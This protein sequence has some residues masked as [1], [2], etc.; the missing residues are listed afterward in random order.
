MVKPGMVAAVAA[1]L[2]S[3]LVVEVRAQSTPAADQQSVEAAI[4]AVHVQLVEAAGKLDANAL[5]GHVLDTPT[6]PIIEDGRL[7]PSR[8]AAL[9]N[10][11]AGF[12]NVANISYRYAREHITV[13]SPTTAL[14]VAEGT[15][16]AV[17][18][19]GREIVAPF[20]ETL[21]FV[22]RDG[23]WKILHAHRSAPNQR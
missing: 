3:L 14:W 15:A 2:V 23:Q 8:A 22:L 6:P 12:Q 17:L 9:A 18:P 11:V 16:T 7:A 21:V 5:Y 13:L 20:A 10:T 4:R 19:D 1:V